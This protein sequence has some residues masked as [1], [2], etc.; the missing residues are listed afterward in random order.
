MI[1]EKA[2]KNDLLSSP[3]NHAQHNNY[4]VFV[5]FAHREFRFVRI[6]RDFHFLL[7]FRQEFRM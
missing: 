1:I 4:F 2:D 7:D 3:F 6:V 5:K